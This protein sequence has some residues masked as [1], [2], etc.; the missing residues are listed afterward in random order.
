MTSGLEKAPE[1]VIVGSLSVCS[2][3]ALYPVRRTEMVSCVLLVEDRMGC[4]T[5]FVGT[6]AP[7]QRKRP[8]R[9]MDEML[10]M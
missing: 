1:A 7:V 3:T 10:V 6:P 2:G 8:V 5:Q 9:A 4:D